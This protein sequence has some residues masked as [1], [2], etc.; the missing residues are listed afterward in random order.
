MRELENIQPD[1]PEMSV[2]IPAKV[3][4]ALKNLFPR[5][6]QRI[7][8]LNLQ[9][10]IINQAKFKDEKVRLLPDMNMI[11]GKHLGLTHEIVKD[12]IVNENC[13]YCVALN[14]KS[15][16]IRFHAMLKKPYK[17]PKK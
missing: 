13:I 14:P 12:I 6:G 7:F 5:P 17:K 2:V 3:I 16:D 9:T 1:K 11:T 4:K 10:G 8:E 15:A